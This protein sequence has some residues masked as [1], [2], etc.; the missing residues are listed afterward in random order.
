M[1]TSNLWTPVGF[2]NVT[3]GKVLDFF[4]M[5]S[6]GPRYQTF[7]EAVVVQFIHL[8]P[9]M[10]AFVEVYPGSVDIPTIT[11]EWEKPSGNGVFT[12]TQFPLNLSW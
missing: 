3:R 6:D 4:Y 7:A 12:C 11:A 9:Y 10:P 8:D 5:S 1:V 2:H